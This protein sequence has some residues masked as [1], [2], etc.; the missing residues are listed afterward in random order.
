MNTRRGF[1]LVELLVVV[2]VIALLVAILLPS[3]V[4][5]RRQAKGAKCLA[6]L[7]GMEIAHWMYMT[8][9]NDN[10][11]NV[12]LA[13]GGA[14][15]LED[16]AWIN[17]LQSYYG[18]VLIGRSPLDTSP[19]WGPYP[20]GIPI[21]GGPAEQRRHTSYGIN[22]Y[23]T[24]LSGSIRLNQV[25][26]PSATV[27][28]LIMAFTGPFAGADHPHAEEWG[29]F[30]A[31][32]APQI[33]ANEIQIDAYSGPPASPQSVSNY[34]FLDGHAETARFEDVYFDDSQNHFNPDMAQ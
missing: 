20:A 14:H 29:V 6:N 21:P 9:N 17:T 23:L 15:L 30:G 5:A 22:S 28:F 18:N 19:H 2:A 1:T 7:R 31:A 25:T 32:A 8:D 10:F 33:A 12:G 24:Q 16:A 11:I 26:S 13:H 34:G 4:N 27:H 3:L